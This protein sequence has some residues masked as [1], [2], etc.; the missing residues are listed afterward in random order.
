VRVLVA[1]ASG[2]IGRA[3]VPALVAHPRVATV[4]ALGR[5]RHA[6][7]AGD[8][9]ESLTADVT[10]PEALR[11]AL[12]GISVAYYLVHALEKRDFAFRNVAGA[13]AFAEQAEAA[14]V[15]RI[16]Y[17]GALSGGSSPHLADRRAVGD[18]LR[19]RALP[20][21]EF[22]AAAVIGADSLVFELV[23]HL[24]ERMPVVPCPRGARTRTQPI[25]LDDVVRYLARAIDEPR[26][27]G[28]R[29][30]IGGDETVSWREM[31]A[32]YARVA[33]LRRTFLDL[34]VQ[35]RA[36]S[37]AW[38][39]FVSP[40]SRAM[41]YQLVR[42]MSDELLVRDGR[43]RALFSMVHTPL[44][45]AFRDAMR[46]A[47]PIAAP[48]WSRSRLRGWVRSR[49]AGPSFSSGSALFEH[50]GPSFSSGSA[51]FEH[52]GPRAR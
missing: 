20:V 46:A 52:A 8:K 5:R 48:P 40:V 25:A 3:L 23:R 17:L 1:G 28:E 13:R 27:A 31:M 24:V 21:T 4:R 10:D 51:L 37:A 41:A 38:V 50:A 18:A 32:L 26:S 6:L 43:A 39:G 14:G 16:V 19:S 2:V 36:L 7:P 49:R 42:G 47:R 9:I 44:E 22:G 15:R 11:T 12:H 34:P 33:G 30:D 45:I 29:F 35:L